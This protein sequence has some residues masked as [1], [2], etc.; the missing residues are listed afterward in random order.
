MPGESCSEPT[1]YDDLPLL[2]TAPWL[3]LG[4]G[5]GFGFG[6][7]FGL[8][9]GRPVQG[10]ARR[11]SSR[12]TEPRRLLAPCGVPRARRAPSRLGPGRRAGR[13]SR[14][15]SGRT[16]RCAAVGRWAAGR[17]PRRTRCTTTARGR[18]W[19]FGRRHGQG[20]RRATARASSLSPV[21]CAL[22]TR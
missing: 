19:S 17:G 4:L 12:L 3:G 22:A 21:A 20:Y 15:R 9:L 18:C 10:K 8:G 11:V 14:C 6:F 16:P 13:P 2:V 7:G 1:T 5:F